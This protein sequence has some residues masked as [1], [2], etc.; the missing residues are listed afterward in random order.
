MGGTLLFSGRILHYLASLTSLTHNNLLL[1][2]TDGSASSFVF[3]KINARR[4]TLFGNH[5][6][7]QK[8]AYSH[9]P[10]Q[11][12]T[13]QLMILHVLL[14]NY[15]FDFYAYVHFT[16]NLNFRALRCSMSFTRDYQGISSKFIEVFKKNAL[17]WIQSVSKESDQ[18]DNFSVSK[19]ILTTERYDITVILVMKKQLIFSA[20]ILLLI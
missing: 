17:G 13:W 7:L 19:S 15:L 18:M 14:S 10:F 1:M 2:S 9:I 16:F 11:F 20:Y 12:I 4:R 8:T 3:S 6:I 5:D